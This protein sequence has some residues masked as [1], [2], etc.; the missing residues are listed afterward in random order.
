MIPIFKITNLFWFITIFNFI[1]IDLNFKAHLIGSMISFL[2][3]EPMWM[4]SA[5]LNI[6]PCIYFSAQ[7][8]L[9]TIEVK[10]TQFD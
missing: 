6:F 10:D 9:S 2:F 1:V 3:A 7:F 8:H 5:A 4:L